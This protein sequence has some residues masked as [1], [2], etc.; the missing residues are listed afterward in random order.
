MA[1]ATESSSLGV[2]RVRKMRQIKK[3]SLPIFFPPPPPNFLS[4]A[5]ASIL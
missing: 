3:T 1:P 2:R 4:A 5:V